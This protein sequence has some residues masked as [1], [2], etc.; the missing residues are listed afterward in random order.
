MNSLGT[1]PVQKPLD[2]HKFCFIL[3]LK[4][5]FKKLILISLEELQSLGPITAKIPVARKDKKFDPAQ[6]YSHSLLYYHSLHF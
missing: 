6:L 4:F 1:K 2:H 3:M 5:Q